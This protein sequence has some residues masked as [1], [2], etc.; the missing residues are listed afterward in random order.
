L[1]SFATVVTTARRKW[2]ELSLAGRREILLA[3]LLLFVYGFFQQ[4]PVWN[5]Y[6]RYDLV[7]ALVDEGTTRIDSFHENT[8]DKAFYQGHWYSDKAPGTALL[9][10]P[11]YALLSLTSNLVG[12][13]VPDQIEAVQA[14]AFVE[15]GVA[16]T[17]LVLLLIRFLVP[18]V[19]ERWAIAVGLAYAFGSIA[20]PFATMFFGHAASTAALFGAF[21]LLHRLKDQPSDAAAIGAGLLAGLAVLIEI[22]VALGVAALAVYALFIGRGVAAR[23]IA[24][25]LPVAAVLLAYNWLTFGSP[26]SIGYQYTPTFSTQNAQGLISVVWPELDTTWDLLLGPRGLVRLA[27][28]FALAPLGLLAWRR[29]ELRFELLLAVAICAAFLT[30]NSGALNPFGGWT[31]GPRYLMPA[32]PF[33]AM[34]VACVPDRLRLVAAPLMLFS[35]ALVSVASVTMPNAPERY[36][37]PLSQLW[38]PRLD[39]GQLAETGAWIRWGLHGFAVLA[40]LAVGA[41]IGILAVG[42]SLGRSPR[43]APATA[44]AAVALAV[45]T[46]AFSFPFPPLAPVALPASAD[47]GS[48]QVSIAELG[49][50]TTRVDGVDEVELWARVQ[51]A[52]AGIGASRAQFT[53]WRETGEGVWSAFYGELPIAAASRQTIKMTWRPQDDNVPPGTYRYGFAVS[54][55]VSDTTFARASAPDTIRFGP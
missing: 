50:T 9:G 33:A 36:A 45:L 51:N 5:E 40:V 1:A 11:V 14:L 4:Q 46:L 37:D 19:G 6:S 28:W 22:P 24:G 7:R 53:V 31:P 55:P 17:I 30:Y 20:F 26:L 18:I 3:A 8:G 21:Y 23:F 2:S 38:L 25:G 16:T 39:S 49:H 54:D 35:I 12:H 44:R 29:R 34:L 43:A 32:L 13:G 27:P 41:A 48:P 10:V 42:L 47:A 15:S 52:G